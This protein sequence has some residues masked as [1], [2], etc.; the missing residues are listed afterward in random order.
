MTRR[1][2]L[3][4]TTTGYQVRAFSAAAARTGV[5]LVFATDRCQQLS[6]PW[7]DRAIPVRFHDD[8][9]S[10]EAVRAFH[11]QSPF[12]AVLAVGDR[13]AVLAA[14]VCDALGIAGHPPTAARMSVHKAAT[15]R[16]LAA[17]GLPTPECEELAF[18]DI[19]E[20]MESPVSFPCVVKPLAL[21]G[22]RG[23]IRADDSHQLAAALE[24][25]RR[26][27]SRREIQANRDGT[28]TRVVIEAF[29][30]GREY[31][32]EGVV[33]HGCFHLLALFDKPDPLDGP[34]FEESI[35]V[36][37]SQQP[38]RVQQ[39]I[40]HAVKAAV[41][42]LGFHHGSVHAECRVNDRGVFVLE[43]AARPIGGLCARALRFLGP[44]R[45]L[46]PLE[47]LLLRQALGAPPGRYCRETEASGVMMIPIP[48]PGIYRGTDRVDSAR[49]VPN[50]VDVEMTAKPDQRLEPLPEGASYL[51]FIFARALRPAAVV[52]ALRKA[53]RRLR[54]R[55]DPPIEVLR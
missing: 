25:V 23:V 47:E 13:P 10:L 14:V 30:T 37:P 43:V 1:V 40:E 15:R 41:T 46:I 28:H 17:A 36:T 42:A 48:R 18:A 4:A 53:H 33:H 7:R 34:F 26:L 31:A 8:V 54:V 39:A 11:E 44:D 24:R 55:I 29:V 16:C 38:R 50:I 35:Y 12:D 20:P 6:D 45:G 9:G 27:L 2:L 21:S 3:I 52:A 19:S 51:G 32:V 22:S 5:E 49:A